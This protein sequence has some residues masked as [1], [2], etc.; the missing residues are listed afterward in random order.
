MFL[1]IGLRLGMLG[2]VSFSPAALFASGEEGA[3]FDPS[4]LSTLF[5]DSAG[6]TPV[7]TAGQPVG[8]MLDKSGMGN[9]A[10]QAT[11]SQRPTYQTGAGLHWLAFDGVDDAMATG[12]IAFTATDE[13]S[14]FAGV[15][16]ISTTTS[17]LV[18]SSSNPGANDG[19]FHI[20]RLGSNSWQALNRGT[21]NQTISGSAVAAPASTVVVSSAKISTPSISIR[22]NGSEIASNTSTQG[23]GNYGNYAL[24]F[25]ARNTSSLFFHGNMYGLIARG[26]TTDAAQ[27]AL[28]ETYLATKS[29]VTL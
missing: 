8:L 24:Y 29:G 16:T 15:R 2:S 9:N 11:S 5:Q 22:E 28:T 1:G 10:T 27:I 21:A 13:M 3:W 14:I 25:G 26:K 4:D 19:A 23:S 17:M 6:T 12:S 20:A 7:T 18:E